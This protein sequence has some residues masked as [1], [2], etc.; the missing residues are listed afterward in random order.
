M[1]DEFGENFFFVPVSNFR[2]C[3]EFDF[4]EIVLIDVDFDTVDDV[5]FQFLVEVKY[6]Q[7]Q[8]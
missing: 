1:I 3:Y 6:F 2:A 5:D 7:T 8:V 4:V